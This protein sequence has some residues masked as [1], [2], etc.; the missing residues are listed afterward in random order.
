MIEDSV[1]RELRAVKERHAARYGYD[2]RRMARALRREQ[3]KSG[4]RVVSRRP[5]RAGV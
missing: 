4:R 5:R 3:A 2:V 1:I